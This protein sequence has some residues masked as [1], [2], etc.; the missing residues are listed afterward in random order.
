MLQNQVI[1]LS[2]IWLSLHRVPEESKG[3]FCLNR[4]DF[5]KSSDTHEEKDFLSLFD[6]FY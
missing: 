5:S 3:F 2:G 4:K 1:D 6:Y